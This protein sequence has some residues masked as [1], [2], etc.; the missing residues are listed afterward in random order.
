MSSTSKPITVKCPNCKRPVAWI[1]E[2]KFKPFCCE[3]CKL[4]D[5][6]EWAMEE[7]IIPGESLELENDE[8]EDSFFQ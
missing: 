3:R 5:L 8:G 1:P 2:E 6:G 7:K 4:I